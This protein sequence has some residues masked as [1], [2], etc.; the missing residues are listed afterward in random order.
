MSLDVGLFM[1]GVALAGQA[2]K[3]MIDTLQRRR[4]R[5]W[6]QSAGGCVHAAAVPCP[7]P[8]HPLP[9]PWTAWSCG[10]AA[11]RR[12]GLA[13]RRSG[14]GACRTN[15]ACRVDGPGHNDCDTRPASDD[16]PRSAE[17]APQ[18]DAKGRRAGA[19]WDCRGRIRRHQHGRHRRC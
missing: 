7:G 3:F 12:S 4:D 18:P 1:Q 15:G 19:R 2:L 16:A 10:R 6:W 9:R 13:S 8:G 11:A 17:D 5:G 14:D